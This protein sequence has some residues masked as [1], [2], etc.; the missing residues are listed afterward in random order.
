MHSYSHG[1]GGK[2]IWPV[3]Q[4]YIAEQ[5]RSAMKEVD[6]RQVHFDISIHIN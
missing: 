5:R 1:L 2:H 3:L 6:T 4:K